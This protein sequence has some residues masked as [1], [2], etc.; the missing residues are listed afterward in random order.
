MT[1]TDQIQFHSE[2]AM[3]ELDQA[4]RASCLQ[5]AHAHFGL[6]ALHLDRMRSLNEARVR[7]QSKVLQPL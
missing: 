2:R 7:T 6:S 1:K 4:L 3:A 5:A